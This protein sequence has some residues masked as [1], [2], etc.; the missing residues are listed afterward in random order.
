MN[1]PID[2][3]HLLNISLATRKESTE[4][5]LKVSRGEIEKHIARF[6]TVDF[7]DVKKRAKGW[8]VTSERKHYKNWH[9]ELIEYRKLK[10][11]LDGINAELE[12]KTGESYHTMF[13]LVAKTELPKEDFHRVHYRATASLNALHATVE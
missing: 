11:Q 8:P 1:T 12:K 10:V 3:K 6:G 9:K 4:K 13:V 7:S 5:C 2:Q